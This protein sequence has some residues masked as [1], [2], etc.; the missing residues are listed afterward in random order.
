MNFAGIVAMALAVGESVV[1]PTAPGTALTVLT[2][3]IHHGAG[4]DGKL[5]LE[6]IARVI[7]SAGADVVCMQEMD[8][9]LPRTNHEDFPAWFEK[10]LGMKAVF[11]CNY[12]FDGGEY[13]VVTLTKLPIVS[14]E[15]TA[16]P[17]PKKVEPRGC[18]RVTVTWN[19]GEVDV[20]NTHLGL[21]GPERE[22]QAAVVAKL[23][24]AKRPVVLAGDMNEGVD[25]PALRQFLAVLH[26]ALTPPDGPKD[27]K[28][29]DHILASDAF[30]VVEGRVIENEETKVASDHLPRVATVKLE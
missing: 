28:R 23:V 22:E 30:A 10:R 19:G 14:S 29:I 26:D 1:A 2:Y 3:N 20:F 21:K 16:L 6:R 12:K 9:N 27:A 11:G 4:M 5:D 8:R 24:D 13:G 7:E 15:N 18:L 17:N 25:A